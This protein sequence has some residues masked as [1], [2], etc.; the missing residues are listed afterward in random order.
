M[1]NKEKTA[2]EQAENAEQTEKA[3]ITK[4]TEQTEQTEK[5]FSQKSKKGQRI[6]LTRILVV[7]IIAL[8]FVGG[9]FTRHF[10][11]SKEV[12]T[13]SEIVSIIEKYGHI[14]D[15]DGN[16]RKLGEGDYANALINGLLD[17]YGRYYSKEEY[18][19]IKNQQNGNY[20]GFGISILLGDEYPEVNNVIGN[21][22]AHKAGVR[23]GDKLIS[24]QVGEQKTDFSIEFIGDL[25][26]TLENSDT[27]LFEIE[28]QGQIIYK[29]LTKSSYK[30]TY[31]KYYDNEGEILIENNAVGQRRAE[32]RIDVDDK[33]ALIAIDSFEGNVAN[34]LGIALQLMKN[35][36]RTKL[37][38][39]LRDNGGGYMDDLLAVSRYLI[40]N[41][42]QKTLIAI[43]ESNS[44]S[45]SFEMIAPIK[46]DNN[47][48]VEDIVVLAND[49]SASATECLIGAMLCYGEKNFSLDKLI[50]EKNSLGDAKTYGKGIMQTTY[51]L[52]NGGAL[53]LTTARILWPDRTT[54]IHGKGISTI[55]ENQVEKA[56]VLSRANEIL[57]AN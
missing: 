51:L 50:I 16:L 35:N 28:R 31:V 54:C 53:K 47:D 55:T 21:S 40:Y 19:E 2:I 37:I 4:Q 45:E 30:A 57:G 34:Q 11:E 10:I 24:G 14:V 7:L 13:T 46:N 5:S 15:E 1:E 6:S 8:S 33:T 20:S 48:N 44:S 25:L 39:D 23:K 27:V 52:T 41:G 12:R 22:P 9:F 29:S 32:E 56:N 38:L 42:G 18:Q 26:D 49:G 17:D 43:A 36:N 3:E